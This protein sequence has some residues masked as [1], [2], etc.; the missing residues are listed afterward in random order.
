MDCRVIEREDGATSLAPG[1][2]D[3]NNPSRDA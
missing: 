2:D 3:V 1:N